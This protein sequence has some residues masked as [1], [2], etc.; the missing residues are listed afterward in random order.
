MERL[1]LYRDAAGSLRSVQSSNSNKL[2]TSQPSVESLPTSERG[3]SGQGLGPRERVKCPKC[4]SRV[5]Q[6]YMKKHDKNMHQGGRRQIHVFPYCSADKPKTSSTFLD[7]RNHLWETHP[8][9][10]QDGDPLL[11]AKYAAGFKLDDWGRLYELDGSYTDSAYQHVRR[12][13][14]RYGRYQGQVDGQ[15]PGPP[16]TIRLPHLKDSTPGKDT[17][18]TES[19]RGVSA[20][21]Q[22]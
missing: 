16:S 1:V 11:H 12:I 20:E 7:W 8:T 17:T 13:L 9:S 3:M 18:P 2:P 22:T 6:Q 19:E 15:L 5:Q 10:I 4:G 14:E 21:G